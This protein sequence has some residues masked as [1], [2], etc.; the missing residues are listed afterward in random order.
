[1]QFTLIDEGRPYTFE[2][3]EDGPAVRIPAAALA[4]ALGWELK[5]Q[6]FCKDDLCYPVPPASR[7]VT[8]DGVDIAG[9]AG[10]IGRPLALDIEERAAYLGVAAALRASQ[11]A[12]LE[13]PDFALPDLEGRVHRL[14]DYRGKKILLAT[15]GSW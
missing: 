10:L 4:A 11:L 8:G 9:F 7:V 6:G 12:S 2:A 15:Y 1:M 14:S 5:P 13:A 3:S